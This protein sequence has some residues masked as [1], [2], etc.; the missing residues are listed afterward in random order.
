MKK[1][2]K[3]ELGFVFKERYYVNFKE[4]DNYIELKFKNGVLS[5]ITEDAVNQDEGYM[6]EPEE[7]EI[8]SITGE[9]NHIYPDN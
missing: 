6:G 2:G 3:K 7:I 1:N 9:I 4:Y 5:K 8:D